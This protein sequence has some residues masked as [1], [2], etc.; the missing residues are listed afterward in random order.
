MVC[1]NCG[2]PINGATVGHPGGCNPV[3]LQA[4]VNGGMVLITEVEVAAGS[5]YFQK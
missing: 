2:A 1:K 5:R 4:R 3:P